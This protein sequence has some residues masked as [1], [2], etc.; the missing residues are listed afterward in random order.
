VNT[1]RRRILPT[2]LL[3]QSL[4]AGKH[5]A[6]GK[7]PSPAPLDYST[8]TDSSHQ[9]LSNPDLDRKKNTKTLE[10]TLSSTESTNS[11]TETLDDPTQSSTDSTV[12]IVDD[13]R[14]SQPLTASDSIE[15]AR[16][17]LK[18]F[19]EEEEAEHS[20]DELLRFPTIFDGLKKK[21]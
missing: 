12:L 14:K 9:S 18:L 16:K 8:S 21:W 7:K 3:H 6:N 4:T 20:F 2:I 11:S 19:D 1:Q 10:Q 15:R 17:L 13:M 5:H